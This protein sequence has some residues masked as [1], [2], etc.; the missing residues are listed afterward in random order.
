MRAV[1]ALQRIRPERK[2]DREGGLDL[3]FV[4]DRSSFGIMGYT[5]R[6]SAPS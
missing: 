4:D 5:N 2:T 6:T 1:Q 3:R